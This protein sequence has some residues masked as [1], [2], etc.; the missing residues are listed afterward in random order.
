M[1]K[2]VALI[3]LGIALVLLLVLTQGGSTGGRLSD[4]ESSSEN[5]LAAGEWYEADCLIVDTSDLC[6]N[7]AGKWICCIYVMNSCGYDITIDKVKLSWTP[8]DGEELRKMQIWRYEILEWKGSAPSGT[9]LDIDDCTLVPGE[10]DC[11]CF[12]FD[13][14][15]HGKAFTIEFTMGDGTSVTATFET[16]AEV[17]SLEEPSGDEASGCSEECCEDCQIQ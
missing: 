4:I 3:I 13:S 7:P 15:M 5:I 6:L 16:L 14:D 9:V 8:D 10:R 1:G 11:I 17:K 12:F 2:K